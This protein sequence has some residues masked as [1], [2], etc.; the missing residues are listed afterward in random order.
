MILIYSDNY[1]EHS[2]GISEKK[3]FFEKVD[4]EK[5][6]KLQQ[7]HEKLS[8]MQK[9]CRNERISERKFFYNES[10]SL[11][12]KT[13]VFGPWYDKT[14]LWGYCFLQNKTQ[15]NLLSIRD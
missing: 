11:R 10:S 14:C 1:C 5:I 6:S 4:F 2:Y 8:S 9:V 3:I 7:K 13:K 12:L 15:T